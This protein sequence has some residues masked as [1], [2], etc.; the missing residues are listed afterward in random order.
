MGMSMIRSRGRSLAAGLAVV[1]IAAGVG[2][3]APT[4]AADPADLPIPATAPQVDQKV[5]SAFG[6]F[7]PAIIGSVATPDT[8]GQMNTDLLAQAK[9]LAAA[10]SA[11]APQAT[12]LWNQLIGFLTNKTPAAGTGPSIPQ[13][14]HKPV[15][16]QFLYPTIGVGCLPGGNSVGMALATAGPQEAPAPGPK[17]GQAGFV[18]TSLGT[19][20]ALRNNAAPLTI[21]WLNIDNGRTGSQPLL[22]N[23][24]IN[25]TSGPG[26]FTAIA[27]TGK[28]RVLAAIYGNVTT[29]TKGHPIG[30]TIVPT[31]GLAYI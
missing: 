28:G 14:P 26:T 19:G 13:G 22:P 29:N 18:Y 6:N 12:P 31:V 21:N 4:A 2:L 15:I 9:S 20:P 16:Q 1:A 27:N 23:P 17:V 7:I 5:L 10:T 24:K 30:C 3:S 8:H 25:A 11:A